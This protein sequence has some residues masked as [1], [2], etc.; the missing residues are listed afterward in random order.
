MRS[1]LWLHSTEFLIVL[2]LVLRRVW[3]YSAPFQFGFPV[4]VLTA[5]L[6]L[7]EPSGVCERGAARSA[8]VAH[9]G[10]QAPL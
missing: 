1:F 5:E 7:R 6:V 8:L 3:R 4:L 10:R 9:R 2:S